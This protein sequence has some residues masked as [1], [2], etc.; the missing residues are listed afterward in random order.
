MLN[1]AKLLDAS[2]SL[3]NRIFSDQW[4]QVAGDWDAAK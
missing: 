2:Q 4:G 1:I 3:M